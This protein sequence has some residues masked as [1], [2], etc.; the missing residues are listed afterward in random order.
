MKTKVIFFLFLISF[1][2]KVTL[3]L[4]VKCNFEEVYSTGDVQNGIFLVKDKKMRYQYFN[5]KL[6]TIIYKDN[7]F[8]LIHNHDNKIVQKVEK[9]TEVMKLFSEIVRSYPKIE[10]SYIKENTKIL[11]EKSFNNFIKRVSVQSSQT[12]VS[13]NIMNCKFSSIDDRYFNHFDLVSI[14]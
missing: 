1:V 12:N 13:I 6:Y 9:N 11:V 10:D 14:N 2:F 7:K 4:E 8:F 5:N 3:A